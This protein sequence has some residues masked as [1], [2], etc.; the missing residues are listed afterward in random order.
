LCAFYKLERVWKVGFETDT[1]DSVLLYA[2]EEVLVSSEFEDTTTALFAFDEACMYGRTADEA[3]TSVDCTRDGFTLVQRST[4][5]QRLVYDLLVSNSMRVENLS[6][7]TA[8]RAA[9][10]Q[11]RV[12]E[13]SALIS[14]YATAIPIVPISCPTPQS[15]RRAVAFYIG[16]KRGF[17]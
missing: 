14:V 2:R 1:V 15:Y 7:D 17:L 10:R 5:N 4:N 12:G 3:V 13:G 8:C 9:K 16:G 11:R 6:F